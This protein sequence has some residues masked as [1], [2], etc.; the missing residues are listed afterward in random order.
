M[1]ARARISSRQK[2]SPPIVKGKTYEG[3]RGY[4]G[5]LVHDDDRILCTAFH[6]LDRWIRILLSVTGAI[7]LLGSLGYIFR[8]SK[9]GGRH[10]GC[11]PSLH[12]GSDPS[13]FAFRPTAKRNCG[14][15][16]VRREL[17]HALRIEM[18]Q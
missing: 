17:H 7:G 5:A 13:D 12:R 11:C 9:L 1:L 16:V 15:G 6:P 2:N 4:S 3:A 18:T 8:K 14:V 10:R